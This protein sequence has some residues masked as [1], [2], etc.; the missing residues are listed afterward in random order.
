MGSCRTLSEQ[1]QNIKEC[2]TIL[3]EWA[4]S[5][6]IYSHGIPVLVLERKVQGFCGFQH[7]I[8]EN[9]FCD[10]A[11]DGGSVRIRNFVY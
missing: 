4:Y 6:Y 8:L 10:S 5:N 1:N 7:G 3:S 2:P 9:G 11:G